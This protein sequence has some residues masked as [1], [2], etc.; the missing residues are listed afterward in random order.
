MRKTLA[1][2]QLD[3]SA[4]MD[5]N[6]STMLFATLTRHLIHLQEQKLLVELEMIDLTSSESSSLGQSKKR[7]RDIFK[8]CVDVLHDTDFSNGSTYLSLGN[9]IKHPSLCTKITLQTDLDF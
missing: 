2:P 8:P 5:D 4:R 9:L 1:H 7:S 6:P 3:I